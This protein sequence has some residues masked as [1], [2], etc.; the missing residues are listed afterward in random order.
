MI[1][2]PFGDRLRVVDGQ[3]RK[4]RCY[5]WAFSD[6]DVAYRIVPDEHILITHVT[7][8]RAYFLLETGVMLHVSPGEIIVL[9]D[10]M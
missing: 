9:S 3:I 5:F 1:S 7:L 10:P 2:S 4:S 6:G 8:Y